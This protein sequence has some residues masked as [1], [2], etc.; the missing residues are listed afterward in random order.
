MDVN[1]FVSSLVNSMV[2]K[3]DMNLLSQL[4]IIASG[5]PQSC[6]MMVAR[7]ASAHSA[8]DQ[9]VFPPFNRSFLLNLHV[10]VSK[11]SNSSAVIGK[12][13]M[14]SIATVW[15][16]MAGEIMGQRLP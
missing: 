4:L 8:A 6:T 16:G 5:I 2:Q 15:K 12:A 9:V 14:K 13:T 3:S 1:I 10:I 11:A 7:N